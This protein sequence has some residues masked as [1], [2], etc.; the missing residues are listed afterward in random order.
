MQD[1]LEL[2]I[3]LHYSS[4]VYHH[5][6]S[7]RIYFNIYMDFLKKKET[8]YR[9][10][11]NKR[12]KQVY[13]ACH[14]RANNSNYGHESIQKNFSTEI[15]NFKLFLAYDVVLCTRRYA[16]RYSTG[17]HIL[18]VS[19]S[20]LIWPIQLQGNHDWYWKANYRELVRPRRTYHPNFTRPV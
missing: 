15:T 10:Q 1:N 19:Y 17:T 2:L 7:M 16:L 13:Q 11:V 9:D 5:L 3:F 6:S 14:K 18:V 4:E 20:C 8:I 12:N